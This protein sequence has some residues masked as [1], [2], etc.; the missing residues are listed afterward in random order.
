MR[1]LIAALA[2]GLFAT[3]ASAEYLSRTIP[4]GGSLKGLYYT[5]LNPDCSLVGY[6][7]IRLTSEP[8]N[9]RVTVV[10]GTAYTN[11]A[12]GNA[13]TACNGRRSPAMLVSY[14]PSKGF[15]GSDSFSLEIFYQAGVTRSDTV[16][17]TVK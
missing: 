1:C 2:L 8:S 15:V 12:A 7:T 6:P 13:R 3:S 14:Q 17:V 10:K 16:N 4:A 5:E 11:Y 9:G